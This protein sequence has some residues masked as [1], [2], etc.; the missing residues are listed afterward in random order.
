M[1][2]FSYL[3]ESERD[4]YVS[5]RMVEVEN[6]IFFSS[7]RMIEEEY[8]ANLLLAEVKVCREN[9]TDTDLLFCALFSLSSYLRYSLTRS[10]FRVSTKSLFSLFPTSN[11]FVTAG[12][13]SRRYCSR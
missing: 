11:S 12:H 4:S 13:I 9:G 7:M 10:R 2:L 8:N 6:S 1:N 5:E 3:T